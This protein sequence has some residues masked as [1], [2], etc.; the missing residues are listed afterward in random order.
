MHAI[1]L[2]AGR[3]VRMMPVT[4]NTPKPLLKVGGISLIERV[5]KQLKAANI[6]DIVIN[7]SYLG[8]KI[9]AF[10]GDG[11]DFGIKIN[12]SREHSLALETAGGIINALPLL[13]NEP[14][15]AINSDIICDYDLTKLKFDSTGNN[16]CMAKIV[17]VKNP[18]HNS[19]GDFSLANDDIVMQNKLSNDWTFSGIGL[20]RIEVFSTRDIAKL[21]LKIIFDELIV[22]KQLQADIHN[23]IWF[24]IGTKD[25][26]DKAMQLKVLI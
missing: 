12:Y 21:P 17:L 25:S 4:K 18:K 8:E 23:G 6:H 14:F 11:S 16:N 20:Y 26:L 9:E 19:S 5:I 24:D 7:T 15:I 1:I 13:K 22:N 2:A 3:G 10:L